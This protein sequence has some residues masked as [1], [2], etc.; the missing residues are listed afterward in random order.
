MKSRIAITEFR[1]RLKD[2]TKIG[3]PSLKIPWGILSI[4]AD[5]SK[6]FYG[7]FDHST[8]EL[9]LN[10]NFSPSLYVLKGTYKKTEENLTVDYSVAP[11]GQLRIAYVKYFPILALILCNAIFYFQAKPPIE[12][13]SIFNVFIVFITCFSRLNLK[14][15][16]KKLQRKFNTLFEI[17]D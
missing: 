16:H 13:Y 4:F 10:S 3:T 15:Q 7:N 2:H 1:N 8:F 17:T 6:C 5:Q 11:V 12:I 9:I 14:W